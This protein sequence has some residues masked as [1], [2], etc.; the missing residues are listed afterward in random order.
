MKEQNQVVKMLLLISQL[1]MTMLTT[2]F[3]CLAVGRF[4][5]KLFNTSWITIVFI[6]LGILAGYKSVYIL[7]KRF[8]KEE[9]KEDEYG[10]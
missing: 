10:Q 7:I 5:D 3:I 9:K 4:L 8:V 6:V 1:G 2:I